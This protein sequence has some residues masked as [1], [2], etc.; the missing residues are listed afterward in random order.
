MKNARGFELIKFHDDYNAE[1]SIQESSAVEPHIWLGVNRP[2]ICIMYKDALKYGMNVS[3]KYPE[4]NECGWCDI[5]LPEE[6]LIAIRMHLS[7]QQ[8]KELAKRLMYFVRHGRLK[9]ESN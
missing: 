1:C 5:Q 7:R 8:A 4:T 2:E 3:K 9:E 6:T